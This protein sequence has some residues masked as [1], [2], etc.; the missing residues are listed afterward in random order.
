MPPHHP[1]S[2]DHDESPIY[3]IR[4]AGQLDER[5]SDWFGGLT[6]TLDE[7]GDTLLTGPIADQ[8]ALHGVLRKVRDLGMS[9]LSVRVQEP[10]QEN[11]P[12]AL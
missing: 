3:E 11:T 7:H 4:I 9:L 10:G 8:A 5:W 1:P 6:L 12:K 2:E